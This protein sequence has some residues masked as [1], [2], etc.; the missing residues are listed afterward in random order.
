VE[1]G[2]EAA[3]KRIIDET[4][5]LIHTIRVVIE[6][7]CIVLHRPALGIGDIAPRAG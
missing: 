6:C 3:I 7:A 1:A 4:V 5:L 2:K